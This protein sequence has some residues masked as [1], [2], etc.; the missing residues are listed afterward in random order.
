PSLPRV[1]FTPAWAVAADERAGPFLARA[2]QGR[3]AVLSEPL[4]EPAGTESVPVAARSIEV[5]V[6]SVEATL[7]APRDGLAVV[8]DPWFPGWSATVDGAR[9]PLV[10]ADY[11][12]MAV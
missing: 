6:N 2:A 8:L 4:D 7:D 11:A 10:R 5:R 9:A 3:V 1:F 12:F